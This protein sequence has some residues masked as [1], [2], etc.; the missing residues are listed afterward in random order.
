MT[1]PVNPLLGAVATPP[2]AEVHGWIAGRRFGPEKPLLDV[3]QAVPGYP[4]D[5]AL[6]DHLAVLVGEPG[7][8]L[9]TDI[10]GTPELRSALAGHT[11]ALYGGP[12]EASEVCI[13]AG[14]NHHLNLNPFTDDH[15]FMKTS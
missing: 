7:S 9:Y 6:T 8:A 14:C 1:Y 15:G 3:S 11:A 2:V 12:V 13:T 5:K 4:P 10:A